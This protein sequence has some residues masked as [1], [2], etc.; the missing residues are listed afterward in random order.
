MAERHCAA[1]GRQTTQVTSPSGAPMVPG[2]RIHGPVR[3][4]VVAAAAGIGVAAAAWALFV[5]LLVGL[6]GSRT[7]P[8]AAAALIAATGLAIGARR[9]LTGRGRRL[10]IASAVAAAAVITVGAFMDEELRSD[11][12]AG[13]VVWLAFALALPALTAALALVPG[14]SDWTN[15]RTSPPA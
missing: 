3:P 1:P 2:P 6:G 4:G 10:L 9:V 15:G 12:V 7:A 11:G 13:V 14:V 8:L 5:G